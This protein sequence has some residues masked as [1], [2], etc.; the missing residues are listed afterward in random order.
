LNEEGVAT[1]GGLNG[2]MLNYYNPYN[3]KNIRRRMPTKCSRVIILETTRIQTISLSSSLQTLAGK[4]LLS[5]EEYP[6]INL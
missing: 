6:E 2:K 4:E 5:G 3:F 1:V